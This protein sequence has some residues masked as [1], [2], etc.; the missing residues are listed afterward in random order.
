MAQLDTLRVK[1]KR[2][3]S[4]IATLCMYFAFSRHSFALLLPDQYLESAFLTSTPDVDNTHR[5]Q[6]K[7]SKRLKVSNYGK[8]HLHT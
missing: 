3:D 6:R 2:T 8:Y 4:A 1:R 5:Q 7:V